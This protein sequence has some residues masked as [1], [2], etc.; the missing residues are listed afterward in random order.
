[1]NARACACSS[2][3]VLALLSAGCGG[4]SSHPFR[5]AVFASCDEQVRTVAFQ[6]NRSDAGAELPLLRRGAKL[7]GSAPSAGVTDVSVG[8]RPVELLLR[9]ARGGDF[10]G[11]LDQVRDLVE[12][13]GVEAVVL[14]LSVDKGRA[15]EPYARRHPGVT[16]VVTDPFEQK[17]LLDQ[18]PPNLF[19]FELDGAQNQA[20]LGAYAYKTLGWR[21]AVTIGAGIPTD[22]TEVAGFVAE[23]CS[24][25]GNIVQRLWAPPPF[26]YAPLVQRTPA[27]GID[28]FFFTGGVGG[29][30]T[31]AVATVLAARYPELSRH[32]LVGTF[33]LLFDQA[34]SWVGVV[35]G[36]VFPDAP[37]PAAFERY[38]ADLKR[39]TG[40]DSFL[41]DTT[42]YA[43]T[44]ALL[45]A[46]EQV[47][48]DTSDGER[49]FQRALARLH[50][51]TPRG[52]VTLDARHQAIG[53]TYLARLERDARGKL[54]L[55]QIRVVRNVEATFGGYFTPT[56]PPPSP[57]QPACRH[58]N[59][60]PW[61]R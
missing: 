38:A 10:R 28:G 21:N 49:R 46:L 26:S 23:F 32:L 60:P 44:E 29:G 17:T 55:K 40:E 53:E 33:S 2:L 9:C 31:Q 34:P 25:G 20:G 35:G 24:L 52:P 56:G 4:G 54:F 37:L 22:W 43:A 36:S 50:L 5:I 7:R 18:P 51:E 11:D 3:A 39:R 12:R 41:L 61:A 19:R 16:F 1:M 8:G 14:G 30:G 13:Q 42:Y 57:T 27:K 47:H 58:G 59:P 15:L 48:G 6:E 45:E